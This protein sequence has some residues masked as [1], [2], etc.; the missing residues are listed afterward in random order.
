MKVKP[1][2]KCGKHRLS[3]RHHLLPVC[4]YGKETQAVILCEECHRNIEKVYLH[5][6]GKSG[7]K[8]NKLSEITYYKLFVEWITGWRNE[9]ETIGHYC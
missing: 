7:R 5:F 4:H 3:T 8:R 9:T 1:C 2:S 6:E